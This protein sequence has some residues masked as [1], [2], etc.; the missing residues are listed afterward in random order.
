MAAIFGNVK[1]VDQ[2]T[3]D[4]VD[5]F[6]KQAQSLLPNEQNQYFNIP[7]LIFMVTIL[8]YYHPEYFTVHGPHMTLQKD[9][10]IVRYHDEDVVS[11]NTVYGNVIIDKFNKGKFVWTF[12]IIEPSEEAIITIGI[13]ASKREF[14]GGAFCSSTENKNAFYAYQCWPED[15]DSLKMNN[16]KVDKNNSNADYGVIYSDKKCQVQMELNMDDKTLRYYVDNEDQGIAYE[17]IIFDNN[18]EYYMCMSI[19]EV[20]SVELVDFQHNFT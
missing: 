18:E 4:I 20:M 17:G 8:Y 14:P 19:D 1:N 9:A 2:K 10:K 13:D 16:S 3:K 11:T 12:D 7:E 5:G 6:I 15:A